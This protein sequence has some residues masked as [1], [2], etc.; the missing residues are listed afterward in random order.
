MKTPTTLILRADADA[1]IGTGHVMR[2][3][4]LAQAWQDMGGDAVLLTSA[5]SPQLHAR[6]HGEG[7]P[8]EHLASQPGTDD[9]ARETSQLAGRRH[10]AWVVLDGYHFDAS[11]QRAIKDAGLRL[12]AV[13][14]CG[15]AERYW[16][17]LVLNQNL[18]AREGLY[19]SR[20]P[21]T[22]LLLGSQYVL[23]RREFLQWQSW[24]R[25]TPKVAR[26]VLVTLGGTDPDNATQKVIAALCA[27]V[28]P[29]GL[30]AVPQQL[31]SPARGRGVGVRARRH[32]DSKSFLDGRLEAVVVVGPGNPHCSALQ[33][34]VADAPLPIRIED[35]VT[36]MARWMAWADLAIGAAGTTSW[37]RAFMGLPSVTIV[38]ADNQQAIAIAMADAGISHNLGCQQALLPTMIADHL[39]RLLPA[40]ERRAEMASRGRRIVDGNGA[41]R[42]ARRLAT[43]TDANLRALV[44]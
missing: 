23:L 21:H 24:R 13:D 39:R 25:T 38:L 12:L 28:C 43:H 33:Q 7:I 35:N 41:A 40:T 44:H 32:K 20:E 27:D 22:R 42:V 16:A 31:P 3:L 18:G 19:R 34:A 4:A 2:S 26:N 17:D 30:E 10:A 9:D 15:H 1:R 14:D 37:E 8:C 5:C 29:S 6:M 11:Y 36:D